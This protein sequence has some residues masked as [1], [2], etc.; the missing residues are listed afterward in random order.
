MFS[1]KDVQNV[2]MNPVVNNMTSAAPVTLVG[3][4]LS[5]QLAMVQSETHGNLRPCLQA[6]VHRHIAVFISLALKS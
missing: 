4:M 2:Y 1:N 6:A 3:D 5:F